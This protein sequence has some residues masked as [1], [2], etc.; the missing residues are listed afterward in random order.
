M[1]VIAIEVAM[2][3]LRAE[4]DDQA[5]VQRLLDAAE[6]AAAEY[7]NRRFYLDAGALAAARQDVAARRQAIREAYAAELEAA[8]LLTDQDDRAAAVADAEEVRREALQDCTATARGMVIE[9][10]IV[11]ACL[12]TLGHLYANREDV[13]VGT[14]AAKLPLGAQSLLTPHRIGMGV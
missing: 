13:V 2:Q 9:P 3:H 14:I 1:S 5:H 7:L 12:L 6:R 8:G 11:A 4:D 10:D